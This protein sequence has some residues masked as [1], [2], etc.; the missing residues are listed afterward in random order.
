MAACR[1]GVWLMAVA[2]LAMR[3][4]TGIVYENDA[5][6]SAYVLKHRPALFVELKNESAIPMQN[7]FMILYSDENEL[8]FEDEY[9][10]MMRLA[11]VLS[12]LLVLSGLA[13]HRYRSTH[14]T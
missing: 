10:C 4:M 2:L 9:V 14:D 5:P 11:F 13:C 3:L 8:F 12:A 7:Q 1:N 6:D